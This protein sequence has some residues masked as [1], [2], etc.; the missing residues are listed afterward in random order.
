MTMRELA[1]K[2][3]I[4]RK[5]VQDLSNGEG[6]NVGVGTIVDLARALG[7]SPAWLAFGEGDGLGAMGTRRR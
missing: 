1:E 5:T 2:A 6:G 7:V 3:H 4:A